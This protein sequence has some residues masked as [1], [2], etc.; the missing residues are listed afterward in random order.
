MR[1][2]KEMYMKYLGNGKILQK[3]E[4]NY[5]LNI[6]IQHKSVDKCR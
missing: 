2:K 1:I 5:V 4:L 3:Q 6:K